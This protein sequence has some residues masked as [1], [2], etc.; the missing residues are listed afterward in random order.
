MLPVED[1]LLSDRVCSSK[2]EALG[3]VRQLTTDGCSNFC[4]LLRAHNCPSKDWFMYVPEVF[5]HALAITQV[6]RVNLVDRVW[7]QGYNFSFAQGDVLY[8]C[9]TAYHVWSDAIKAMSR[10]IQITAATPVLTT[11]GATTASQ[12]SV[13]FDLLEPNEYC[14]APDGNG[15]VA[16][17]S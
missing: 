14:F 2:E 5:N 1:N 16:E 10:C 12:G 6:K 7:S 3:V 17:M 11:R 15:K 8:D 13:T 4:P 9:S